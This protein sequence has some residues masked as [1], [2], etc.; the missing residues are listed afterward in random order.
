MNWTNNLG[1]IQRSSTVS[2]LE[3]LSIELVNNSRSRTIITAHHDQSTDADEIILPQDPAEVGQVL[4]SL[5]LGFTEWVT[6]TIDSSF[7]D[8][9]QIQNRGSLTHT[10]IDTRL[11]QDVSPSAVPTFTG[12]TVPALP[13][14]DSDLANKEY[15]DSVAGGSG[16]ALEPVIRF[17][18][19]PPATTLGDRY[20]IE[21]VASGAWTGLEDQIAEGTGAGWTFTIPGANDRVF[22]TSTSLTFQYTGTAWVLIAGVVDFD[23]I[24]PIV[25]K[26]DIIVGI[27]GGLSTNLPVGADEFL[28]MS[29]SAF[30]EGIRWVD[31]RELEPRSW[32]FFRE[33][34]AGT[35]SGSLMA[36]VWETRFFNTNGAL[37]PSALV[38]RTGNVFRIETGSYEIKARAAVAEVQ[39]NRMRWRNISDNTTD[40][41]GPGTTVPNNTSIIAQLTGTFIVAAAFKDFEL[42]H[43]GAK[44]KSNGRGLAINVPG[45]SEIYTG[46]VITEIR[47]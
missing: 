29:D 6:P 28:M 33:E 3:A 31:R 47:P 40:I 41:D 13:T 10:V 25:D 11:G 42:Q 15:V 14:M 23:S 1:F 19:T 20:I 2:F 18:S 30:P 37:N 24:S 46:I 17:E 43:I 34:P 35:S 32:T 21:A 4:R 9:L 7:V 38:N 16:I 39:G 45:V 22:V 12:I 26:G 44:T 5:G 36:A 27:G 8:H